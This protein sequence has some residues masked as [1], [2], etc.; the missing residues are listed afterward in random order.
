[1]PCRPPVGSGLPSS[2]VLG[3]AASVGPIRDS[4]VPT[5]CPGSVG[6][7]RLQQKSAYCDAFDNKPVQPGVFDQ[8]AFTNKLIFS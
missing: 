2:D 8:L 1:M 6:I 4:Q 3:D 7:P 5:I